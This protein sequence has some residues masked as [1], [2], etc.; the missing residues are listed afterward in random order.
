MKN[1]SVALL[2]LVVMG[3]S[4]CGHKESLTPNL[5][6]MTVNELKNDKPIY[7]SYQIDDTPI[8]EFAKGAKKFPLFGKLFQSIARMV[9]NNAIYKKGGLEKELTAVD[10]DLSSLSEMNF[11]LIQYID[12]DSLVLSI[13]DPKSKDMLSFID[14][15]EIYA[16]LEVPID[17]LEVDNQGY[18]KLVYFN[19]KKDSFDCAGNCIKLNLAKIQWKKLLETNKSVHLRPKIIINSVPLSTMKLA[20]SI[21]FSVKFNLGF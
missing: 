12:F 6:P 21:D 5:K 18:S 3:F 1:W 2:A 9:A 17:G 20:G 16:K 14:S 8:D 4:S 11:D 15:L 10:V 19:T 7:F 13:K